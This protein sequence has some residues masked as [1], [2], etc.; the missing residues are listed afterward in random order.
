MYRDTV[1]Q[2]AR[3]DI[4]AAVA[5]HHE[6]GRDYDD[7]VAESLVDRIGAEIDKRVDARL[8]A[9]SSGSRSPAEFSQSARS[10]AMW[11]GAVIGVTIGAAITGLMALIAKHGNTSGAVGKAVILTWVILAIA[12]LATALVRRHPSRER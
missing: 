7:A 6:L 11:T 8:R 9:G 1:D 2:A 3:N 10:Q 5:V 12:G 4:T